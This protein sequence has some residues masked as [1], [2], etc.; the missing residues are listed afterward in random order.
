MVENTQPKTR[1][2]FTIG[3]LAIFL[4]V[5][6]KFILGS[7]YLDMTESYE[8]T[9]LPDTTQRDRTRAEEEKHLTQ[10]PVPIDVAM[11]QLASKGRGY[12]EAVEPRPSDDIAP[13][14]G[15]V[16]RKHHVHLPPQ[17]MPDG[18]AEEMGD[19][20]ELMT[21]GGTMAAD[22]GAMPEMADAGAAPMHTIAPM[23]AD[24]GKSTVTVVDAGGVP[25]T[26]PHD[27]GP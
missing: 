13:L 7:Y 4:L 20:G 15:W 11:Q 3:L 27:A 8:H 21:D 6:V 17:I 24:A 5:A 9:L 26:P 14:E 19:G 16:Q 2:L 23:A 10:S 25:H 1:M 22:A 12:D 18:G